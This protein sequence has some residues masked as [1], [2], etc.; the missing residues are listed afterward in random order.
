MFRFSKKTDYAIVALNHIGKKFSPVTA[1]DIALRY[2]YSPH[3][4][5]NILKELAS[6]GLLKG[7]RGNGGGYLLNRRPGDIT[8]T[9]ILEATDGSFN[10]T[11]CGNNQGLCAAEAFCPPKNFMHV[12][13]A[14]IKSLFDQIRLDDFMNFNAGLPASSPFRES[15]PK[16]ITDE[17]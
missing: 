12:V 17:P 4:T 10:L 13:Q 11:L 15:V 5:A 7:I 2:R 1:T 3:L 6:A 8:L 9:E 14:R 16:P